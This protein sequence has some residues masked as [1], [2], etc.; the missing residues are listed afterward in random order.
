[1]KCLF[2]GSPGA[3]RAG[4]VSAHRLPNPVA[5]AISNWRA[6]RQTVLLPKPGVERRT[7]PTADSHPGNAMQRR[8]LEFLSAAAKT[9]PR[10]APP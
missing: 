2:V 9:P 5:E 3:F 1:V 10:A 4:S 7:S 6:P 8:S